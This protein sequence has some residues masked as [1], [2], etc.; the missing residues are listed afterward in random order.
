MFP[1]M[2]C[3]PDAARCREAKASRVKNFCTRGDGAEHD[4]SPAAGGLRFAHV[5]FDAGY[6]ASAVAV[7]RPGYDQALAE[8][9]SD[10]AI[11][12]SDRHAGVQ[13]SARTEPQPFAGADR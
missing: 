7:A 6:E 2:V 13:A 8:V 1:R 10:Q 11:Y 3:P 9:H 12:L 4:P 5:V